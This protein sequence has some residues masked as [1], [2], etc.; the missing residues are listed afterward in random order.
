[1]ES[2][3]S[4]PC[5]Q[6]PAYPEV[7]ELVNVYAFDCLTELVQGFRSIKRCNTRTLR[8]SQQ[9][10]EKSVQKCKTN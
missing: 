3:G 5:S 1:M 6:G 2:E 4:F 10:I 7:D 9:D 8:K